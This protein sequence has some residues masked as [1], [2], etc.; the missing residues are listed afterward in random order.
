[1]TSPATRPPGRRRQPIRS[2]ASHPRADLQGGHP[3]NA[4]SGTTTLPRAVSTGQGV[5]LVAERELS[6]KLRSKAYLISTAVLLLIALAGV[7]WAGVASAN[8]EAT[9]VAATSA[10]ASTL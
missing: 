3:V 1:A 4:S 7:I 8:S 6:T 2:A 10:A 9:P 5:W